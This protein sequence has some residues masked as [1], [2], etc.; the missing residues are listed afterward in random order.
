MCRQQTTGVTH[1]IEACVQ[2]G[3]FRLGFVPL[4]SGG[5]EVSVEEKLERLYSLYEQQMFRLAYSVVR[6]V[7]QAEDIVQESFLKIFTRLEKVQDVHSTETKRW[8]LRIVK[9]E[10]IDH[11]RKNKRRNELFRSVA[12]DASHIEYDNNTYDGVQHMIEEEYIQVIMKKLPRKYKEILQFRLFFELSTAETAKI[13]CIREDAVRKRY[14]RAK[15]QVRR[16]IGEENYE[17]RME[18]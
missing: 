4:L 2:I 12:D 6:H 1:N 15:E 5:K 14:T 18:L 11:Y 8:I 7:E 17:A 16:L 9:N 10:A 13:L 3:Y